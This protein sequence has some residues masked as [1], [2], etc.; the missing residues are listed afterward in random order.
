MQK[1]KTNNSPGS[2]EER[3][4]SRIDNGVLTL[5]DKEFIDFFEYNYYESTSF[6]GVDKLEGS[7]ACSIY[8]NP[9]TMELLPSNVAWADDSD[10][11]IY[12]VEIPFEERVLKDLPLKL[13]ETVYGGTSFDLVQKIVDKTEFDDF[14]RK[15]TEIISDQVVKYLLRGAPGSL[16]KLDFDDVVNNTYSGL[17]NFASQ[18]SRKKKDLLGKEQHFYTL[19]PCYTERFRESLDTLSFFGASL[20][21]IEEFLKEIFIRNSKS[22]NIDEEFLRDEISDFIER[23]QVNF[24]NDHQISSH[25]FGKLLRSFFG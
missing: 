23:G 15:L 10:R 20:E 8:F 3:L 11:P 18:C 17:K 14:R 7:Y 6:I 2:L 5:T 13:Q 24:L 1:F 19:H 12:A 21:E 22:S 4:Q 9:K 16:D 25:W